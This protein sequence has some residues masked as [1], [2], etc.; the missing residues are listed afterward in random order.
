[1][2]FGK[3]IIKR[4]IELS[5]QRSLDLEDVLQCLCAKENSCEAIMTNDKKFCDCGLSIDK[6]LKVKVK[7][8]SYIYFTI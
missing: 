6:F 5:L 1:V 8:S 3:N 7:S 4:T 2:A